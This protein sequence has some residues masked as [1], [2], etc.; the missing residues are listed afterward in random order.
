M[1]RRNTP[2][3]PENIPNPDVK[4]PL[5]E[6]TPYDNLRIYEDALNLLKKEVDGI[7]REI[8]AFEAAGNDSM[9]RQYIDVL[10]DK[11]AEMRD[12]EAIVA[13]HQ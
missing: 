12:L 7:R 1:E 10:A 6:I 3:G 2:R 8:T 9:V 5:E 4:R 13:A 11:E